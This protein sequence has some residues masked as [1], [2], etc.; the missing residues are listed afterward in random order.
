MKTRTILI[1]VL[2]VIIIVAGY[3]LGTD[4]FKQRREYDTFTSEIDGA[5]SELALIPLPSEELEQR[6]SE[7]QER[8]ED[9]HRVFP[10]DLNTTIIINSILELADGIGIKAIPLVTQPWQSGTSDYFNFSV[11]RLNLKLTGSYNQLADF[12]SELESGEMQTLTAEYLLVEKTSNVPDP[13]KLDGDNL[14]I[15]ASLDIAIY[16]QSHSAG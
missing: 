2:S 14:I 10:A 8:L 15:G 1:A 7:A 9:I 13:E 16:A 6:L 11:F 5:K 3:I 12:L 4:Y